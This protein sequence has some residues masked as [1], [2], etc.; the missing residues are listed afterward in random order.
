M[1]I[2]KL[3]DKDLRIIKIKFTNNSRYLLFGDNYG[4]LYCYDI[5]NNFKLI[6]NYDVPSSFISDILAIDDDYILTCSDYH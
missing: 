1:K 6:Y 2:I 3:D 4:Y 5:N